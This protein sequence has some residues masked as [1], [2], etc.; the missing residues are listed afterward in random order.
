MN[1]RSEALGE[2]EGFFVLFGSGLPPQPRISNTK[3]TLP[4]M[5]ASYVG[6]IH[7]PSTYSFEVDLEC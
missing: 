6:Q 2:Y 5:G 7:S 4:K 3:S 1:I